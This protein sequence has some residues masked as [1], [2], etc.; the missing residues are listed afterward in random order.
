MKVYSDL[1]VAEFLYRS[2]GHAD[3]AALSLDL[4]GFERIDDINPWTSPSPE[5]LSPLGMKMHE[6]LLFEILFSSG[7]SCEI[8]RLS[9]K[10]RNR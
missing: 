9:S 2:L 4:H 7:S 1:V 5:T 6:T 3:F 8:W 10:C